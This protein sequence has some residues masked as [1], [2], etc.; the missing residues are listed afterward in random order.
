[1]VNPYTKLLLTYLKPRWKQATWLFLL[2]LSVIGLQLYSPTILSRFID[3]AVAGEPLHILVR[4]AILFLGIAIVTQ[5]VSVLET[6][7]AENLGMMAT[8]QLRTDIALHCMQLDLSFHNNHTPGELIERIDGD[9]TALGNFFSRFMVMLVGNV[10]LVVGVLLYL[11]Q[12]DLWLTGMLTAMT[13]AGLL[14]MMRL[15]DVAV[16]YWI[17]LRQAVADL[18]S[19]LEERLLGIEDLHANGAAAYS[20][21][22]MQKHNHLLL[23]KGLTAN[24][25]GTLTMSAPRL[26]FTIVTALTLLFIANL[27]TNNLI[28]LGT[29][30]LIYRY[31]EMLMRPV[32]EINRQVQDFQRAMASIVRVQDLLE[33]ESKIADTGQKKLSAKYG[34]FSDGYVSDNES[35]E[36]GAITTEPIATDPTDAKSNG[37]KVDFA[38]VSFAYTPGNTVLHDISFTL[39]PGEVLGIL[40]HTGSGKTTLTRLLFR[41]F[42]PTTGT[43]RL[44]DDLLQELSLHELRRQVGLVTQDVQLFGATVRNNLTFFD[45]S[46][47]DSQIVHTL[48]EI[49]LG[50]W[51][52]ALPDGLETMLDPQNSQLSAGESQLLAFVRIFLTDP[53]LIILDEASSRLDP[54]TEHHIESAIDRLFRNRTGIVIAHRLATVERA[55]TIMILEEGR[56]AEIGPRLTLANSPTSKFAQLLQVGLEDSGLI[57]STDEVILRSF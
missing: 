27:Y 57:S 37:V 21:G 40:G 3:G 24:T 26:F 28:T 23:K 49:G 2:L 18:F 31:S 48:H 30:Y 15:R 34:Y 11:S 42:D 13:L 10:L 50:A 44:N 1:M 55:D 36:T 54:M 6:Y 47:A 43:V 53:A 38:H 12:V 41:L 33:T 7:V 19:F 14:I 32:E 22:Q 20:V 56:I 4:T 25:V 5:I 8:N 51:L 9:V 52:E 35:T 46:I 16:P 17:V 29:A 39:Q 45:E